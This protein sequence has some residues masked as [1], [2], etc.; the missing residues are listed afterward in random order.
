MATK[1]LKAQA[2]N[3]PSSNL[4]SSKTSLRRFF[5]EKQETD[6][7]SKMAAAEKSPASRAP[8]CPTPSDSSTEG[9]DIKSILTQLPSKLDLEAMFSKMERSF[10]DKLQSLHE[11]V[12]PHGNVKIS[13]TYKF[14]I[15]EDYLNVRNNNVLEIEYEWALKKWSHCSKP[16]GG[17][18]Q[19]T[20]YGCRRKSDHKMVHKSLCESIPKL[21]PIRRVCNLQ[22]CSQPIWVTGEWEPCSVTCGKS[23]YQSRT[24]RC[25]QPLSDNTNRSVHSKYCNENRPEAKRPCNR[26]ACPAHWRIGP[27]SQC[28]V[29]CSNGTQERQVMCSS[30]DSKNCI[31]NKPDTIRICILPPCTGNASDPSKKNYIVQWRSKQDPDYPM[32]KI[33]SKEN[34]LGDKSIICRLEV[35]SRYCSMP[36]FSRLCCKPCNSSQIT[37]D[38]NTVKNNSIENLA[39]PIPTT[40]RAPNS[41]VSP[42]IPYKKNTSLINVTEN[43]EHTNR[44]DIPYK[45]NILDNEVPEPNTIPRRRFLYEKT[46]NQRIQ[47]LIAEKRKQET[48]KKLK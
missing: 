8:A 9:T 41:T 26:Q 17:G 20:K 4:L 40:L 35:L 30:D 23:G 5:A 24:V 47:Q 10:G 37:S 34:C 33:S 29:T 48:M 11:E 32:H 31:D 6:M 25:I 46:K 38:S 44:V 39:P 14:M 3:T 43:Q 16:C 36:T 18:H 15:H 7:R 22:E 13:L 28:S 2:G 12:I 21:K 27:W 19:F 42:T 45:V 1:R